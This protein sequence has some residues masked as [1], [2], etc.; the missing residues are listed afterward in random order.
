M[1]PLKRATLLLVAA[2]L[3]LCGLRAQ[4]NTDHMMMVG[5]NALYFKDYV[6]SI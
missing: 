2:L 6:L 5:R 3:S 1:H 4:V